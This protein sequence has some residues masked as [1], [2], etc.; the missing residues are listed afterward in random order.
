MKLQCLTIVVLLLFVAGLV[1]AAG[2]T[3]HASTSSDQG[4]HCYGSSCP[5]PGSDGGPCGPTC[6]SACCPGHSMIA[7]FTAVRPSIEAPPSD[8]LSA[9][10]PNDLYPKD[11]LYRIFHPPRA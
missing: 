10:S 11:I 3:L 8:E 1:S 6:P 4:S 5:D 7:A 2:E 9:L